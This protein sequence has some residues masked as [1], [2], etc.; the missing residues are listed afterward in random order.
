MKISKL[1]YL[2]L[3]SLTFSALAGNQ[4]LLQGVQEVDRLAFGTCNKQYFPQP[5]WPAIMKDAPDL[6]LAGGDNVY[7]NDENPDKIKAAYQAQDLISDFALLRTFIPVIGL[8]DDHD[9]TNDNANG[10]YK[11]KDLSQ[12]YFLD[13]MQEPL[14]SKRRMQNG[15][16]T[17]Y[18][19]GPKERRIKFILLDTRYF[20]DVHADSPILGRTQ[21]RWLERELRDSKAKLIFLASGYPIL[22]PDMPLSVEWADYPGEKERLLKAVKKIKTPIMF[23]TGD[24]HFS[25]IYRGSDNHVEF[26]S[27]GMTHN[28]RAPLRPYVRQKFPNYMF[29]FNYS[30]VDIA[31]ENSI[32]SL[33]LSIRNVS[34]KPV[35][36]QKL[37]WTS[38]KWQNQ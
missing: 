25:S 26:M 34:G 6:W 4:E 22:A 31:W 13:F 29:D 7:V 36:G 19:F 9:F 12:R 18:S 17:S 14:V 30:V 35:I 33:D 2:L 38:G 21:W 3:A 28:T 5:L 15:I 11:H 20:K 23:L 8:W 1:L 32:P 37:I 27:S 24:K 16:Y 10:K